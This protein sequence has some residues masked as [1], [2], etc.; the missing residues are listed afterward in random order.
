MA[1]RTTKRGN[2]KPY[3]VLILQGGG[4]LG[5]YHIGAYQALEESGYM[6]DWVSGI[7]IGAINSA[8]IVGSRP[9]DRLDRLEALWTEISR[10]DY[11]EMPLFGEFRK[12]YN[13]GSAMAAILFGQPNFF[14]PRFPSPYFTS[15]G[16]AGATSFYDTSLL[17]NT[18]EQLASFE[19]INS[20]QV[21]LSLGATQVTTGNLIFFDNTRQK[22]GPEHVM[23]SGSLPPGFPAIWA[24]DD[25]YWDGGC[26]SNTPLQA[27][28]DDE[29]KG[30]T[31]IFMIDLW[32]AEGLEPQTMNDVLWRQ[33]QIQYAS[34]TTHHIESA[35]KRQN[36]RRSL[37]L[38][39]RHLPP[40]ALASSAVKDA[41]ALKYGAKMDIVHIIYHPGP[42]QVPQSDA[43]FSRL[44]IADRRSAGYYDLKFALEKAPWFKDTPEY[45]GA[46]AHHV[47]GGKIS[48]SY[49]T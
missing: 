49:S 28:L 13:T 5:A 44:S 10:P 12:L 29:P 41:L 9:G 18:L 42:D 47:K 6:P 23:A 15:S 4:A 33:K 8:V 14:T 24:D 30:H 7:S 32:D 17:R 21:R 2:D 1:I 48:S 20:R 3:V 27:I 34:R 19:L 38:L 36:L 25:L 35:V 39:A 37:S 40:T 22:I 43:E 16:T 26:V 11:W 31:L 46:V 45:V